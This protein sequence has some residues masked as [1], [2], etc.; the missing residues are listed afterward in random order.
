ML[1]TIKVPKV[2]MPKNLHWTIKF[3]HLMSLFDHFWGGVKVT[4]T[5]FIPHEG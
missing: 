4:K 5:I 2:V 1:M 3:D